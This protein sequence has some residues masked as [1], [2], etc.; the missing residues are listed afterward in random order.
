MKTININEL[1]FSS[2]EQIG[3]GHFG[4][5]KKCYYN[6][7]IYAY[8]ELYSPEE[9]LTSTNIYKF[10]CL[11]KINKDYINTPEIF[12]NHGNKLGGYLSENIAGDVIGDLI[13]KESDIIIK[14]LKKASENLK[15]IHDLGIIH[16]D[17][18]T[19][20]IKNSC[21]IDFDNSSYKNIK[22]NYN[23]LDIYAKCFIDKYGLIEE[24]DITMFNL[25]S[26]RLL[27]GYEHGYEAL[28]AIDEGN[29]G[30]FQTQTQR[31]ICDSLILQDDKPTKKL[32]IDT[33]K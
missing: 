23:Q 25:L 15:K 32:L 30:M 17:I 11:K 1:I 18:H 16:C 2:D 27:S 19:S 26:Y 28:Q 8:K 33:I 13:G 14:A 29:Y 12:V 20:N 24:L 9:I 21:F 3:N 4:I 31:N 7:K 5:V 6:S 22:P 10:E